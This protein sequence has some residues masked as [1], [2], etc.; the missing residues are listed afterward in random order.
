MHRVFHSPVHAGESIADLIHIDAHCHRLPA[1][2]GTVGILSHFAGAVQGPESLPR[3]SSMG[4]H[5]W[6]AADTDLG[7][8]LE[9]MKDAFSDPSCIALGEVGLDRVQG[10]ALPEQERVLCAQLALAD[11]HDIP[12]ILHDVRSTADLLRI[13]KDF[14]RQTWLLHGF[15]G[16][17][18]LAEQCL[19]KGFYLSL[20]PS[21]LKAEGRGPA[22]CEVIPSDR[23]FLETDDSG[24]DVQDMYD[25][26]R[27]WSGMDAGTLVAAIERNFIRVFGVQP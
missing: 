9:R 5:P 15:R 18:A 23:L 12:V 21:L 10:P 6:H 2:E 17:A 22:L 8:A 25:A 26:V 11:A 14:P 24:L 7:T 13:R 16:S 3:F 4:I 27:S 20:A 1:R 19:G